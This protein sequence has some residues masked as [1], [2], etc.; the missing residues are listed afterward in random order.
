[1]EAILATIEEQNID[2]LITDFETFRN[3]KSLQTLVTG[4]VLAIRTTGDDLQPFETKV[5][6]SQM[7]T[8]LPKADEKKNMVVLYDGGDHS[9]HCYRRQLTGWIHLEDSM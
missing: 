6:R 2:L 7:T 3:S 1:M 8:F 5:N 9:V 4:D